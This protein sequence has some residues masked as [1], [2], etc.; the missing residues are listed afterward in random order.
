MA[1]GKRFYILILLLLFHLLKANAQD[2]YD[3]SL[4]NVL[5]QNIPDTS[6]V[7]ALLYLGDKTNSDNN[8]T[9]RMLIDS[10]MR[11]ASRS[12]SL[13][14]QLNAYTSA[15]L[16]YQSWGKADSVLYYYN[17]ILAYENDS[18]Y[19]YPVA[20]TCGNLINFY[21]QMGD[22][23]QALK[24]A[25]KTEKIYIE[26]SKFKLLVNVYSNIAGIFF[27][28]GDYDK[29]LLYDK[30]G[31][32]IATKYN[33]EKILPRIFHNIGS[34]YGE[35]GQIDS[36]MHY[37][38]LSLA[39]AEN[40]NNIE[41]TANS[42]QA[43]GIEYFIA[44]NTD[45]ASYH[46]LKAKKFFEEEEIFDDSYPILLCYLGKIE[47][48]KKN[49]S[50]ALKYLSKADSISETIAFL[51]D[52]LEIKTALKNLF[53]ANGD[54]QKAFMA[55][56]EFA[57][58]NDSLQRDENI[59]ITRELERK[60][61]SAKKEKENAELKAANEL[62]QQKISSR[63]KI[64]ITTIAAIS[65]L[66]MMLFFIFRNYRNEK[67]HVALLDK[68]NLQLT[69]Q[70]DEI[71]NINQ[72]LQLK[73]LRTQMNPH[74]I[75]NCLNAINNLVV[76]GENDKASNYL[77]NFSKLLRMILD[78]SDKT[79][80]DLEDEIKFIKLYLSLEAMRMGNDF[81]YEVKASSQMLEEDIGVPSLLIQ[82]FIENAIWHGLINKE[83][84]KN[85]SVSFEQTNDV[86]LLTCI[87]ED[88]GIGR[89]KAGQAKRKGHTMLHES[90][91]I[92][93]TQERIE[94]LQYQ[95]KNEVSITINDKVNA[96]NE[97]E[98]TLVKLVLPVNA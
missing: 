88:N 25:F 89:E 50:T 71:L 34:T 46:L 37:Y 67:K 96:D 73:V 63:N 68:L 95:I 86:H 66:V 56:E 47:T 21:R 69:N 13:L 51:S 28:L 5:T 91:G 16:L 18:T 53:A 14:W 24:Y 75:Y 23:Q 6:R 79:F 26:R 44:G 93:I 29:S 80:V 41:E 4:K 22:L 43:I 12:K 2:A 82:P 94:L 48:Q 8:E 27:D 62:Q 38:H 57:T 87:V 40:T 72:L 74:F 65:F 77:L 97:P 19:W 76:K 15:G 54:W 17:K 33:I 78:F 55:Q 39:T 58:L 52:K 20:R 1:T 11:V 32:S 85:L 42:H 35:M 31:L 90:K 64:L 7:R 3:D 83:G 59:R 70:R 30:K 84:K 98:G 9:A 10:A 61:D 60:Y 36:S 45:S 92:R 49:Y 81:S